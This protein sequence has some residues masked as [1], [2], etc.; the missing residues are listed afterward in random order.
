M[1]RLPY[2]INMTMMGRFAIAH[3][4]WGQFAF[5][6]NGGITLAT[7]TNR[8]RSGYEYFPEDGNPYV[9]AQFSS[10]GGVND[11]EGWQNYQFWGN[12]E[13]ALE[14]GDYEVNLTVPADHIVE[15]TGQLTNPKNVLNRKEYSRYKEAL[16]SFDKPVVVVTQEEA[17]AKEAEFSTK[18]S[19]WKFVA[20]NV[21][22]CFCQ[23]PKIYL[24]HDGRSSRPSKSYCIFA[25][26]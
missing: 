3:S 7:A 6:S 26:S 25:L 11:V 12:G 23:F 19:T 17:T 15:A 18:K 1:V 2:I 5:P 14:F 16:N 4:T 21:R 20:N 9:I 24:G 8:A 13:F 22:E 10:L